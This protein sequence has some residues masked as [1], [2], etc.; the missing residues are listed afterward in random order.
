MTVKEYRE[1]HPK[2]KYCI[3][4]DEYALIFR[5]KAKKSIACCAKECPMYA[6]KEDYRR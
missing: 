5:C 1:K 3:H 2:C 4:Y 6:L